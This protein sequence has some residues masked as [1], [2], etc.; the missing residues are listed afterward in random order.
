MSTKRAVHYDEVFQDLMTKDVYRVGRFLARGGYSEVYEAVHA[1]TAKRYAVKV[2]QVKHTTS[3]KTI[4]RQLR[5]AETLL[6]IS[7]PNVVKVYA[8]GRRR[9]D[10]VIFM[11]MDLLIGRTLRQF[12]K[13]TG[14]RVPI[15]WVLNILIGVT[16]G[17]TAIHK[18][19]IVHRDLK[20]ENLH[21]GVDGRVCLFDLGT[22]KFASKSQLTTGGMT[23]GTVEYM[24]PEQLCRPTT[25]DARSDQF[26]LGV[27]AYELLSGLHPFEVDGVLTDDVMALGKQIIFAPHRPLK[28]VAPH[29]P[30]SLCQIVERL[31]SKDPANRYASACVLWELLT[32]SLDRY[33]DEH[34]AFT[35]LPI[36]TLTTR[37]LE[38]PSNEPHL[39]DVG[40]SPPASK[41][42]YITTS[43]VPQ[44]PVSPA[45][46]ANDGVSAWDRESLSSASTAQIPVSA[47]GEMLL[48]AS[49]TRAR[50]AA[51][52]STAFDAKAD[53]VE[54]LSAE[55]FE[56]DPDEEGLALGSERET[57]ASPVSKVVARAGMPRTVEESA[58][59]QSSLGSAEQDSE[60]DRMASVPGGLDTSAL[61]EAEI[62]SDRPTEIQITRA[63]SQ[64][65]RRPRALAFTVVA[66]TATLVSAAGVFT[67]RSTIALAPSGAS[68]SREPPPTP[69]VSALPAG[70]TPAPVVHLSTLVLPVPSALPAP[71]ALSATSE[72]IAPPAPTGAPALPVTKKVPFTA[73]STRG[74]ALPGGPRPLFRM[75]GE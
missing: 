51:Y 19:G 25:I 42:P 17:L 21:I 68:M 46:P 47:L 62:A 26:P 39:S 41:N 43:I 9:E 2:L 18:A 74:R 40:S 71:P 13:D 22:G 15:P 12:K 59:L 75:P 34:R 61:L 72:L 63:L 4:Q 55:D 50:I 11:V 10:G 38:R 29:V 60:S 20:P 49:G 8:I 32:A 56:A 31:L 48:P 37:S 44:E 30:D 33:N 28:E 45:A 7:H 23:L 24:S 52:R 27:I 54:E 64:P 53:S 70:P 58:L 3:Q 6:S 5:E 66:F 1:G 67:V 35:P 57:D 36:D 69:M 16:D 14:G 65:P 73:V